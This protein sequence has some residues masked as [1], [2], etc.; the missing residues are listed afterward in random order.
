MRLEVHAWGDPAARPVVCLHG[1]TGHG[2]RFRKLAEERLS[3]FHVL[4][5]DLRGHGHSGWEEPWTLAAQVDDLLE[6]FDTPAAWVGHS[7]GGR[8]VMELTARRPKLVERAILID[9]AM[10][11]PADIAGRLAAYESRPKEFASIDEALVE[12]S[13]GLFSTPREI[14]DEELRGHLVQ[15]EDGL[16]RYRYSQ[17]CAAALYQELA[18]PPPAYNDLR[19]PTLLVVGAESKLVSAAEAELYH[20]ALDD[21][22]AFRIVPGGHSCLW[23]A[24]E[25]TAHAIERFLARGN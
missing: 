18:G 25:E 15:A 17:P 20:R 12:R 13:D 19:V 9:P 14:L 5:P 10:R 7:L 22:Y 1:V 3:G 8:L 21:L 11:V 16:L 6:T 4:A 2:A 24:F 23:D